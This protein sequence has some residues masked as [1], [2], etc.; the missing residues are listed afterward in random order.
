M[1]WRVVTVSSTPDY[2]LDLLPSMILSGIGVG[3][4]LGTLIAAGVQSLPADR[5]ATGSALVNSFRQISATVGVAVLVTILG[6]RVDAGSIGDFRLGWSLAAALSLGTALLGA[7]L[8]RSVTRPSP[9]AEPAK[10]EA[11]SV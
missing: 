2:V 10:A 8:M 3:L 7:L 9:V 4:T 1:L 11:R 5:T 6:T